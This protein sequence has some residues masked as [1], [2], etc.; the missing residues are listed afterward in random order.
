MKI[1]V[2]GAGAGKTTSMAQKVLDRLKERNNGKVIY[3]ITYTNSARNRIREKITE[4]Y[5]SLPRKVFVETS[6]AFLLRELI[7]PFYHLLYGQQF[8]KVSQIK[9]SDNPGYRAM[10]IKELVDNKIIHVEKIT[11]AAKW[12]V[13][14]KTGDRS[15]TIKKRERILQIIL[16]YL[17]S[18]F[19]DEA[20]DIDNHF[21]KIIEVLHSKGINTYLVGDPKQDLRGRNALNELVNKYQEHVEYKPENNRCPISHVNLANTYIPIMQRQLPQKA[22]F[23]TLSYVYESEIVKEE[24]HDFVKESDWDYVYISKKNDRF[25]THANDRNE[26]LSNLTYEI[27]QIVKRTTTVDTDIDKLV[28]ILVKNVLKDLNKE[29]NSAIFS[30]LQKSLSIELTRQ[31]MGKLGEQLK[32]NR[33]AHLNIG[34]LVN[35]IDSI[36]GL[37]GGKCLFILTTDLAE[38]LFQIKKDQNKTLNYLYVALTRS[39]KELVF[40]ITHEV[41][42]KYGRIIVDEKLEG[43]N[44]RMMS[45]DKPKEVLALS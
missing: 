29:S 17:D 45:F 20:Q 24:I 11:E 32:I 14:R 1:V 25:I 39:K 42:N 43:L 7:F 40:L 5:G 6:H 30:K 38:Y 37:E 12:V 4:L 36:K 22:D 23:G 28:F 21:G 9:L 16:K 44:I 41:E 8:N 33:E 15:E 34:I 27:R 35:S 13:S 18:V 31:D 3:V 10:K 2:A 19:I 26:T